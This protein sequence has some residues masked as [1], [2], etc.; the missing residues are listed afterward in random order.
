MQALADIAEKDTRLRSRIIRQITAPR[1][2]AT[3]TA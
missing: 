2:P 3:C 1:I